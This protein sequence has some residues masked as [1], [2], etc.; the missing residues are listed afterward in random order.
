MADPG[1]GGPRGWRTG[2]DTS[3]LKIDFC[4]SPAG[5]IIDFAHSPAAGLI[6][7]LLLS[8]RRPLFSVWLRWCHLSN[9]IEVTG[10]EDEP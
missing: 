5:L 6:I 4:I 3:G 10:F 7:A 2:I 1:N 9:M 8:V